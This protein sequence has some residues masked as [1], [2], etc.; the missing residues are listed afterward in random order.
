MVFAVDGGTHADWERTQHIADGIVEEPVFEQP[1]MGRVVHQDAECVLP[2]ADHE[3]RDRNDQDGEA[4][5][6]TLANV[7]GTG[8]VLLQVRRQSGTNAVEVVHAVRDR[9]TELQAALPSGYKVRVVR[10]QAEFIEGHAPMCP[11]N[12]P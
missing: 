3:Q 6:D 11:A 8:T 10:D 7:N 5:A 12:R 9:L 4:E 1:E 2:R